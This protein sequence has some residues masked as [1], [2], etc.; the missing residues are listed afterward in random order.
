M[1]G[2]LLLTALELSFL[3]QLQQVSGDKLRWRRQGRYAAGPGPAS[4]RE[5]QT[6]AYMVRVLADTV[7]SRESLMR[8]RSLSVRPVATVGR[9]R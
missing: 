7:R 3:G 1:N 4:Q 8:L 6:E 9:K 5:R 2:V